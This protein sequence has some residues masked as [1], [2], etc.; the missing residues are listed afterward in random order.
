MKRILIP[1]DG[2]PTSE[3]VL[4]AVENLAIAAGA[5]LV[6]LRAI[7]ATTLPLTVAELR[8]AEQ[9]LRSAAE[10]LEGRGCKKVRWIVWYGGAVEAIVESTER[11]QA[12]LVAMVT[13]GWKRLASLLFPSV[14]QQVLR[15]AG[16]PVLLYN[17]AAARRSVEPQGRTAAL[18]V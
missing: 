9:Y 10:R 4:P 16:V 18:R 11:Q 1:L 2:S 5:E 13:H 7:P 17:A 14:A 6:L 8:E 3:L 15:E 12:D